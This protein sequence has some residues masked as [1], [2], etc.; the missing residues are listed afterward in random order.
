[1]RRWTAGNRSSP[2]SLSTHPDAVRQPWRCFVRQA[3]RR[4]MK[5]STTTFVIPGA[6]TD[7]K[8]IATHPHPPEMSRRGY[9]PPIEGDR[10]VLTLTGRLDERPPAEPDGFMNYAQRLETRRSTTPS[11]MPSG[12]AGSHAMPIAPAHGVVSIG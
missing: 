12:E 8:G 4:R 10:W 1:M 5:S 9:M 2:T 6:P 7:W 3:S 11:S